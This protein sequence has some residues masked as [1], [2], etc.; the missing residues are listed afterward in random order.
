ML[1]VEPGL[2]SCLYLQCPAR[3]GVVTLKLI[4]TTA[5]V[6]ASTASLTSVILVWR[7]PPLWTDTSPSL[8]FSPELSSSKPRHPF[9]TISWAASLEGREVEVWVAPWP[10]LV[11]RTCR[12]WTISRL[13]PHTDWFTMFLAATDGLKSYPRAPDG[14][15]MMSGSKTEI[16]WCWKEEF[17]A[18]TEI[19]KTTQMFTLDWAVKSN[20]RSHP[21]APE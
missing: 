10:A 12:F 11:V 20:T 5:M 13:M 6:A 16:C 2:V 1:S 14:T 9:G 7:T 8:S 4:S 3:R 15:R 18:E 19:R 21:R 17:W